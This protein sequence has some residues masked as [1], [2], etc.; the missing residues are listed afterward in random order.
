M[1]PKT[2]LLVPVWPG[3]PKGWTPLEAHSIPRASRKTH[4]R[5]QESWCLGLDSQSRRPRTPAIPAHGISPYVT[6]TRVFPV[7]LQASWNYSWS[8]YSVQNFFSLLF[9]L[10]KSL[11]KVQFKYAFLFWS[12]PLLLPHLGTSQWLL[13]CTAPAFVCVCKA[14]LATLECKQLFVCL[15]PHSTVPGKSCAL[16]EYYLH[17]SWVN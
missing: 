9:F 13:L 12:L 6:F 15:F 8:P 10:A 14:E 16:N 5:V 17:G 4:W 11:Y 7:K 2:T 3:S 1:W